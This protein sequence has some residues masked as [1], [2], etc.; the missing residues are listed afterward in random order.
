MIAKDDLDKL[1]DEITK[2]KLAF[3]EFSDSHDKVV[4][5]EEADVDHDNYFEDV[6]SSY[7]DTLT[8]AK[9]VLSEAK[10][11]PL[12]VSNAATKELV[13]LLSLPKV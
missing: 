3:S 12:A 4:A 11:D 8:K 13:N 5:K 7:I 6:Q 10:T 1:R 9:I 2:L